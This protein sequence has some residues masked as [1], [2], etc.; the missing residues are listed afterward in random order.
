[1][2]FHHY[3]LEER[4]MMVWACTYLQNVSRFALAQ[5]TFYIDMFSFSNWITRNS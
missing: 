2:Q 3:R 5:P 1:M 4:T